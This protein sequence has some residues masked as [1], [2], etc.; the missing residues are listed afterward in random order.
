MRIPRDTCPYAS[1]CGVSITSHPSLCRPFVLSPLLSFI[2]RIQ[3]FHSYGVSI[4]LV[5][6]LLQALLSHALVGYQTNRHMYPAV[7]CS[8]HALHRSLLSGV[9]PQLLLKHVSRIFSREGFVV[10]ISVAFGRRFVQNRPNDPYKLSFVSLA[11]EV[12][13]PAA[14]CA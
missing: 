10:C 6:P 7:L 2:L 8:R 14:F 5:L 12:Q 3:S 11:T 1:A 4:P 9:T 13:E